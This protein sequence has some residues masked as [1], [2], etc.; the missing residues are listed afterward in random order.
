MND[1]L[2]VIFD[3]VKKL[4]TA[5]VPYMLT[6]SVAMN[7]YA[8]PRMTRDIDFVIELSPSKLLRLE[9]LFKDEYYF[10]REAVQESLK[11]SSFFNLIHNEFQ[12]KID[13]MIRKQSEYRLLEF[14]RRKIITLEGTEMF[15]VSKDDLMLSKLFW[16]KDNHSQRQLDDVKNLAQTG[17][18]R[19]YIALWSQG[20]GVSALLKECL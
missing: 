6:G 15:I 4:N 19:E 20:L 1:E 18:D 8:V 17:F 5:G 7:Y 2:I 14:S 9:E 10:S 16:A 12:I 3:V 11:Y 13:C